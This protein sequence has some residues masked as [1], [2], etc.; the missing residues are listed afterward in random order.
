MDKNN[1]PTVLAVHP[2]IGTWPANVLRSHIV[3]SQPMEMAEAIQHIKLLDDEN[4]DISDAL[5]DLPDG[6]WTADQRILTVLF[7]PGR[8]KTG[9]SATAR[10]GS[11][12]TVG[13]SYRLIVRSEICS[14]DGQAVGCDYSHSFQIGP[15]IQAE[16]TLLALPAKRQGSSIRIETN[17]PLDFLSAQTYLAVSDELGHRVTTQFYSSTDG[18][19]ITATLTDSHHEKKLLVRAHSLL[20]DVAGNRMAAPFETHMKVG[21]M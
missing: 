19:A 18:K 11:V 14:A 21:E 15:P 13:R 1:Q 20:E 4:R 5:L 9:L 6:L 2:T 7:H 17:Q 16:L 10:Y 3:F 8:V 12:F